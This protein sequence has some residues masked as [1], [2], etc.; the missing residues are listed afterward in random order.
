MVM[1]VADSGDNRRAAVKMNQH[2][3]LFRA[4]PVDLAL[5]K[6]NQQSRQQCVVKLIR[7]IPYLARWYV[8]K[9]YV[10]Y[11]SMLRYGSRIGSYGIRDACDGK[12]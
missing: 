8:M 9:G 2:V 12:V 3:T 7:Y 4:R 11:G 6:K 1:V 10:W 5:L